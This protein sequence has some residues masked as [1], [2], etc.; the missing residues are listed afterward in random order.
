MKFLIKEFYL[1]FFIW[2]ESRFDHNILNFKYNIRMYNLFNKICTELGVSYSDIKSK[3]RDNGLIKKRSSAILQMYEKGYSIDELST[4]FDR[5]PRL[6][7]RM[8]NYNEKK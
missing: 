6:I 5:T 4:V 8:V 2:F 1:G 7:S 3:K